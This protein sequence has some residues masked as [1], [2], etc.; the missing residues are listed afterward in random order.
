MLLRNYQKRLVDNAEKAL[1]SYNNTLVVAATGAGKTIMMAE[2]L[3]RLDGRQL[4]LQHRQELVS[5]NMSKF[6]Q[7]NEK[8]N[9]GLW[10]ADAK[11][12]KKQTI[13]AMVQS[14]VRHT[15]KMPAFD[16][17]CIDEAH[18]VAAP[19]FEKIIAE[20]KEKNPNVKL[21]GFTATPKRG[22][23]K[24]L[25]KFF[26]NIC[27]QITIKELV[28]LGFLVPPKA[29]VV[30][31]GNTQEDLQKLGNI[32]DFGE[33]AEV[34]KILNTELI[35]SEVIKH[36][37]EKCRQANGYRPTIIFCSTIKHALDVVRAFNEQ[38]IKA[39]CI[40]GEMSSAERKIN[41]DM[42]A[43]G[44]VSVL[45]NVMV[46]TEGFDFPPISCIILLRKSSEK[47][48]FIQMAGRGLRTVNPEEYA[49]IIK[50]DCIIMDFG[51][52]ILQHGDLMSDVDLGKEKEKTKLDTYLT[53]ICPAEYNDVLD[54][55]GQAKYRFPDFEG[56]TGCGAALPI[57]TKICPLCGFRFDRIGTEECLENVSLEMT[58]I[59]ILN[60]SP[61]RYVDLF[62]SERIMMATGFSAW[63]GVFSPDGENWYA[64]GQKEKEKIKCVL[65]G[66]KLNAM[67]AADD[68]LRMYETN[69]SA[70]KSKSWLDD[71]ATSKQIELLNRFHYNLA[72]NA[73]ISKYEAMCYTNFQF[74]KKEIENLLGLL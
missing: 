48:T 57:Q 14:L 8:A 18:H 24:G 33:Q 27:D 65:I 9:C 31:I 63:A 21:V 3:R 69:S 38:G 22:D 59:D 71:K 72:D 23:K 25:R 56:K 30:N 64:L 10:T 41:L 50:K 13:F 51:T 26:N 11:T 53:K 37:K 12:F 61:F 58:E 5:Q 28:S 42:L 67:A 19:S 36:F 44:K 15:A 66:E 68:F 7:I 46:L 55:K 1:A 49:G 52:S 47:S 45:T 35:N 34:A 2:L 40:H 74:H 17:I 29:F 6:K 20:A 73:D 54:S 39:S 16:V 32:S 60:T 4:V 62:S 43:K 70:K